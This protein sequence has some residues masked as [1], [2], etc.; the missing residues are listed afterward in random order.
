M[1]TEELGAP[2][3]RKYDI[4]AWMP[5]KGEYGEASSELACVLHVMERMCPLSEGDQCV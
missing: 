2:A 5:G 3:Y 1:P 4:E